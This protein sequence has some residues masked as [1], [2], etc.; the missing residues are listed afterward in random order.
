MRIAVAYQD[1]EIFGHFGHC[2]LF[3]LY[4]YGEY[5]SDCQKKLVDTSMLSGHQQMAD[6]MK[7]LEVDAVIVG[8]MGGEAKAML[9][10][11]GIVPIVG[12]S[13]DADTASD[14]LVTGQLPVS[15]AEGG[16]GCGGSCNCGG[17]CGPEDGCSC[18]CC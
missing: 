2:P 16:C 9:L 1:G 18:G 17:S 15:P 7:E 13:G 11:Y 8:N 4:D 10:S 5:V 6:K 14:L 3:A 12:Y